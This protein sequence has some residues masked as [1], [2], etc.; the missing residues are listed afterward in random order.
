MSEFSAK[1]LE[2]AAFDPRLREE[3]EAVFWMFE[4]VRAGHVL[5]VLEAEAVAHSLYV[6]MRAEGVITVPQLPLH[7]MTEYNAVHAINVALMAMGAAE[8]M[9]L[10]ERAVR[11]IGIAGL[12]HDIGM[13]RVPVDL[14]SKTEQLNEEERAIV[15]RH[16]VDGAMIIVESDSSLDLAAVVA[17]EHHIKA[18]GSGYPKLIYPRESHR[19]ARLVAV[20]DTY[21]A[22]RSPR[23]FRGSWPLDVVIS[24]L[25]QRAGDEFATEMVDT[26]TAVMRDAEP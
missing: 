12:L 11:A 7:D 5:P 17:Y 23:P 14:L 19:I 21:H 22:L 15:T 2:T 25:Q 4:Q 16:P 10:E 18:D 3:T 1:P 20:C 9:K 26:V 13:V 24:F 8:F 6:S